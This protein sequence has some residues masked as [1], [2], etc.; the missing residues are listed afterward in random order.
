MIII[1]CLDVCD[2]KELLIKTAFF[3]SFCFDW[4]N[5]Y[6]LM[7]FVI[8]SAFNSENKLKESKKSGGTFL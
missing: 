1:L 2:L 6:W 7:W 3:L 4:E 5:H 8:R